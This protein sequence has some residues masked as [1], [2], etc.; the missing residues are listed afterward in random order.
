MG[1]V[2]EVDLN[3]YRVSHY[4]AMAEEADQ[5]Y[6]N[7]SVS[8]KRIKERVESVLLPFS[9]MDEDTNLVLSQIIPR[10]NVSDISQATLDKYLA[11]MSLSEMI[12]EI[13]IQD[14]AVK[15]GQEA[16]AVKLVGEFLTGVRGDMYDYFKD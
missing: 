8:S 6:L 11:L 9:N 7:E 4:K 5:Y 3:D 15:P 1:Q 16:L 10:R 14:G 12:T 2:T 13:S